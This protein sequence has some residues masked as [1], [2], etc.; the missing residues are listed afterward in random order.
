MLQKADIEN[1]K[2]C[3]N[4]GLTIILSQMSLVPIHYEQINAT[5]FETDVK[6]LKALMNLDKI[7]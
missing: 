2:A 5:F 6:N 3:L 1:I 7:K 4:E